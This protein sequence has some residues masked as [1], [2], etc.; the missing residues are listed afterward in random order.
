MPSRN[1]NSRAPRVPPGPGSAGTDGG[2]ALDLETDAEH[3]REQPEELA[4][5]QLLQDRLD[6]IA[7]T[8]GVA[9]A[10]RVAR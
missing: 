2:A 3:Q 7:Q 4:L 8:A 6:R 5:G 1:S 9:A 10:A